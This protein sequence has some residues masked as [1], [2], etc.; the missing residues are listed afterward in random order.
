MG[1]L[2]T[3]P[4]TIRTPKTVE[5]YKIIKESRFHTA[6][7]ET[8][9]TISPLKNFGRIY[10]IVDVESS[11][12]VLNNY[13]RLQVGRFVT[14]IKGLTSICDVTDKAVRR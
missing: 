12:P 5:V 8:L 10:I 4:P 1:G 2:C 11:D 3:H 7:T 9:K 14:S 6:E 13:L